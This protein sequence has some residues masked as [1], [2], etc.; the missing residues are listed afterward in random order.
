M[1]CRTVW[2]SSSRYDGSSAQDE[3]DKRGFKYKRDSIQEH[4]QSFKFNC[5]FICLF[6]LLRKEKLLKGF[7]PPPTADRDADDDDG[8]PGSRIT[9]SSTT[10]IVSANGVGA[11]LNSIK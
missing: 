7:L 11:L 3:G 1:K 5:G 9:Y 4:Q 10:Y 8:S 6:I 2:P